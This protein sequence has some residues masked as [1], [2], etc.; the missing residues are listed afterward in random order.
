MSRRNFL[1]HVLSGLILILLASCSPAQV[2]VPPQPQPLSTSNPDAFSTMVAGTAAAFMTQTAEA[3]PTATAT[4]PPSTE[5]PSPTITAT[6]TDANAS[7]SLTDMEDGSTQFFD[8]QAGI[9]VTF[10][11]GWIA[12]RLSE[13][14]FMDAWVNAV[15]DPVLQHDMESVQ[16]LD[17]V[18]HRVHA[19]NAQTG[20]VYEGQG[21][22]I[23]ILF[24]QGDTRE[25]EKVVEDE[26]QPKDLEG[27]RLISPKYQVRPDGVE[28]FTV[29]ESWQTLSSTAQQV[30]LYHKRVIFKVSTGT[31]SIDLYAPLEIKDVALSEFDALIQQ[32]SI[33]EP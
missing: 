4:L 29:D 16:Q 31:V 10:P 5:P 1:V 20:Y 14:E 32:L 22:T 13:Q 18:I 9:K 21:S 11:V 3:M 26:L 15:D 12:V 25:L 17:P 27:Y 2:T 8:Y 24:A 6:P 19:F 33:F 30:M 7:T 28:L 23:A